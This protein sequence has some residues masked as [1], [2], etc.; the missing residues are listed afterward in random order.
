MPR[1]SYRNWFGLALILLL[2]A[3]SNTAETQTTA[4]EESDNAKEDATTELIGT[5]QLEK[6]EV[7]GAPSGIGTRLKIFNETHWCVIQ[8]D[9]TGNIV[10]VHGGTYEF[11]GTELK[12]KTDFA[13]DLT[14]S[15][16]G[17]NTTVKIELDGD[18]HRQIDPNGVFNETWI[19]VK[20]PNPK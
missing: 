5:W 20:L 16:I 6:A 9:E 10:F 15:L 13:G 8:P 1:N 12:T 11:D 2:F 14:G 18:T 17:T 7:P 19:R 4:D 3:V